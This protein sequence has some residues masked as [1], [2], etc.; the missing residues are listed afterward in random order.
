MRWPG[1]PIRYIFSSHFHRDHSGGIRPYIAEGAKVIAGADT[2][3]FYQYMANA[4]YVLFPDSLSTATIEPEVIEISDI[5]SFTLQDGERVIRFFPVENTH[6]QDMIVA[7][8]EDAKAVFVSDLYNPNEFPVP[9][10]GD[11]SPW[12]KQL[13]A[14]LE[15]T[16]LDIQQ[17]IGAHGTVAPW[18]QFVAEANL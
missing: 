1:K 6:A 5:D 17:L 11:F 18:A 7:Y 13:L 3:G 12:A 8:V 10:D 14:G 16:E 2:T 15:L 9:F 4:S